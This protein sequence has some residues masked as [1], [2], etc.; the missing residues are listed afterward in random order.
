MA[1]TK[2]FLVFGGTGG[3]GEA[4]VGRL[5]AGGHRVTSAA[6]DE[7]K[8]AAQKA[9]FSAL[10]TTVCDVTSAASV[11]QVFARAADFDG[12]CLAVGSLLLKP[13]HL[14]SDEDWALTVAQ[15]LNAAFFVLRAG[16][17]AAGSRPV[18]FVFYSSVAARV[19]LPNHEAIAAV[20]AGI[21]G[22]VRSAAATYCG[23]GVRVNAI[24]P[25]L[26]ATPLTAR[27]TGNEASR[28]AS[29]AMHPLGRIGTPE[30]IAAATVWLLGDEAS[31]VTGQVV[32]VDGGMSTVKAPPR[33]VQA[34]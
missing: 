20:K 8:L 12:A 28:A 21:E 15:N 4:V 17:K 27:I 6:R 2:H 7:G 33:K 23:R 32:S 1:Q 24:A 31:W 16:I 34:G 18:S 9:K 22:L 13:A 19:G 3:I 26:V 14:T 25:G 11:E 29:E 30:D 5:L 10:E